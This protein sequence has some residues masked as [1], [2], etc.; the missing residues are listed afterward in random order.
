LSS[1]R[2]ILRPGGCLYLGIE[3]RLGF[4]YCLGVKDHSGLPFTSLMPRWIAGQIVGA[5][6][7]RGRCEGY[8]GNKNVSGYRWPTYS[9]RGYTALLGEAGFSDVS[10]YWTYPSYNEPRY[11]SSLDFDAPVKFLIDQSWQRRVA[12]DEMPIRVA[13]NLARHLPPKVLLT[14]W[15]AFCPHFAIF[16]R[17]A[18]LDDLA[19]QINPTREADSRQVLFINGNNPTSGMLRVEF[20]N[21]SPISKRQM[22]PTSPAGRG[23]LFSVS[24]PQEWIPGRIANLRL[25]FDRNL[26]RTWLGRFQNN[27]TSSIP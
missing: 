16:A 3:N 26:I 7:G 9:L 12:P 25:E 4:Q 2:S 6:H 23:G 19:Q 20:E 24:N 22:A 21:G 5:A 27:R 15:R 10:F 14:I 13:L 17:K 11:I 1:I 18:K 8:R